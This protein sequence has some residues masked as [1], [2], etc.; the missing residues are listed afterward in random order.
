MRAG[1]SPRVEETNPPAA[2][3]VFDYAV[4]GAWPWQL[5]LLHGGVG[6]FPAPLF[7]QRSFWPPL[8]LTKGVPYAPRVDARTLEKATMG[9]RPSVA[10]FSSYFASSSS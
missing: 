9:G 1:R 6:L 3:G 10:Y 2:K 8:R 5:F 4:L 7:F